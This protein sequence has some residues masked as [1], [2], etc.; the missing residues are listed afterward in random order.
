MPDVGLRVGGREFG[1]WKAARI[2]RSMAAL[3][4]SFDLSVSDR[5]PGQ[6]LRWPI[7][8]EDACEVA[9]DGQVVITGWVDRRS[10]SLSAEEHGI[11]V[12]GRDRAGALV[13]C[14]AVL[15]T[16]E[17]LN[18][19][20]VQLARELC[21]PFGI[22]VSVQAGLAPRPVAKLTIDPGDSAFDALE[23]A[24]RLAGVLAVSDG[25]GGIL[26]TRAGAAR[27]ATSLVEGQNVLAA[28]V[29]LAAGGRFR[30]YIVTGQ[31]QATDE[32]YGELA[33]AVRGNAQDAGV[34]RDHRVLM[35][36]AEMGVT[37]EQARQRAEWEATVR[38]G[39]AETASVTVQGWQQADG[40]LWPVNARVAVQL[41]TLGLTG[42]ALITEATHTLGPSGTIT[43]LAL[44]RP[45]AYRPEPVVSTAASG[46]WPE[47]ANK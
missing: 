37:A 2:T 19:N 3:C 20:V 27:A 4:G 22:P 23:R 11:T 46:R 17:Y 14:S 15:S 9:V 24:A 34:R 21:R 31:R 16:W 43:E 5:W 36:R 33:A 41:P 35:V 30:R 38:A 10:I 45:D 7:L 8:E 1:G 25:R 47:L 6:A 26:L 44:A 40:S 42:E 12:A 39:R 32:A 29:D 13:D 18:A 28:S